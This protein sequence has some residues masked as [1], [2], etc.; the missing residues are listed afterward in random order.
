[1]NYIKLTIVFVLSTLAQVSLVN[2]FAFRGAVVNLPLCF[3]L[4]IVFLYDNEMRAILA[5]ALSMLFVDI[6]VAEIAGPAGVAAVI[7][8]LFVIL[9]KGIVNEDNPFTVFPLAFIATFVFAGI[10]W[11]ILSIL[12]HKLSLLLM[13]KHQLIV[14]LYNIVVSLFLYLLLRNRA[15]RVNRENRL[16]KDDQEILAS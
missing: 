4:V 9:Y 3:A 7:T 2:I 10:H 15:K 11:L 5:I 14:A 6:M 8:M 12:G 16:E 1:M 13:V